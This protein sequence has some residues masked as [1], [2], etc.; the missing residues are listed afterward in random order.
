M[1]RILCVLILCGLLAGCAAEPSAPVS[2]APS[3]SSAASV[4]EAASSA[5]VS[6]GT[7]TTVTDPSAQESSTVSTDPAT[8]ATSA[9]ETAS[10]VTTAA[11]AVSA[12][13]PKTTAT[14]TTATTVTTTTTTKTATTT[15]TKTATTTDPTAG[16]KVLFF[17]DFDGNKLNDKYWN[18]ETTSDN[19]SFRRYTNRPENVRVED[20]DLILTARRE[21]YG[22]SNYT[23]ASV[24]TAGKFSVKYGRIEMRAKL[25]YGQGMWPAFWTL[26]DDYLK[27][28]DERGWPFA[29]EIDIM[30]F[31]GVG[32]EADRNK[33]AGTATYGNNRSS[34]NLHWGKDRAH[35]Q[36]QVAYCTLPSG[37]F[38]DDYHIFAIE[39]KKGK[40]EWYVDDI[41]FH[42]M[43]TS[44][45]SMVSAFD[46]YHWL[47]VNL[48]LVDG[49]GPAVDATTPFPQEYRIDYIRVLKEKK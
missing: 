10:T 28:G 6:A 5:A 18:I 23:S 43:S 33:P 3:G 25:P 36:E 16:R 38:N 9:T 44:D 21:K 49:W 4:T 8:P 32:G 26:G 45:S 1:K 41:K 39:W 12:P 22:R 40:I 34:G 15:T 46:D 7:E 31:I 37:I 14:A 19:G 35:H 29:G 11:T 20:G 27:M 24:T 13:A 2:D 48:G 42:E 17:D 30:E 47:I